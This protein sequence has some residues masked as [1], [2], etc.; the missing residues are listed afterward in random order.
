M[1]G[2][3]ATHCDPPATRQGNNYI[4]LKHDWCNSTA[5]A[6]RKRE[7]RSDRA[8]HLPESI[9]PCVLDSGIPFS[10]AS[11]QAGAH[12]LPLQQGGVTLRGNPGDPESAQHG[13]VYSSAPRAYG[14]EDLFVSLNP[15]IL[16]A[17]PS[18]YP[19]TQGFRETFES[20]S[21]GHGRDSQIPRTR[22]SLNPPQGRTRAYLDMTETPD[23]WR[24]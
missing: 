12:R 3:R 18:P 5:M 19:W 14:T 9:R 17:C 7:R 15:R 22:E 10:P 4:Q 1:R 11:W 13:F 8:R 2:G 20:L 24:R 16:G 21:R 23:S 6:N